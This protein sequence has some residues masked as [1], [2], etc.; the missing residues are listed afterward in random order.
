MYQCASTVLFASL[1]LFI[2]FHERK[3]VLVYVSELGAADKLFA[4]D[5]WNFHLY[6]F[7]EK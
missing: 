6:T 5:N 4:C 3:I 7:N 2:Q 1:V